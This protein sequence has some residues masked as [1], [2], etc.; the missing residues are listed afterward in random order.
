MATQEQVLDALRLD[1]VEVVDGLPKLVDSFVE[2][3]GRI[4][5]ALLLLLLSP[6]GLELRCGGSLVRHAG[7]TVYPF[8]SRSKRP[9]R[10]L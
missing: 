7:A 10:T 2:D 6:K 8:I 4:D 3:V 9:W 1:L 5:A